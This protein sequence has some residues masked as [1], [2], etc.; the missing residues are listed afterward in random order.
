[1]VP[2]SQS[3]I[4]KRHQ[5][6]CATYSLRDFAALLGVSYTVA[7]QRAQAGNLPVKPIDNLG[8]QYRFPKAAVHRVLEIE[9]DEFDRDIETPDGRTCRREFA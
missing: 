5:L 3:T 4:S 6:V 1:M 7:H 8:R 2:V 9:H